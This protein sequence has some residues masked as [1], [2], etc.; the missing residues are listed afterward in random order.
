MMI[1]LV[2]TMSTNSLSNFSKNSSRKSFLCSYVPRQPLD[3]F[4][5]FCSKHLTNRYVD[6]TCHLSV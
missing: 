4:K 3:E 2:N 1:S 6:N 5:I